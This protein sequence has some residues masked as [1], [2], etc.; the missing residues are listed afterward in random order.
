MIVGDGGG[1]IRDAHDATN[2][3][4]TLNNTLSGQGVFNILGYLI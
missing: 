2:L 4:T 3:G 1:G